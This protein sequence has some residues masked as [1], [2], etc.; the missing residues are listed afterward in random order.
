MVIKKSSRE[1]I[2]IKNLE[3]EIKRKRNALGVKKKKRSLKREQKKVIKKAKNAQEEIIEDA[4]KK[5]KE[6]EIKRRALN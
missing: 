5:V 6:L 2:Q 3:K 4:R 1:T